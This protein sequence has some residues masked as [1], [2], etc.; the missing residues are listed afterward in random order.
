MMTVMFSTGIR[1]TYNEASWIEWPNRGCWLL[2]T[3]K[4]GKI[5][6]KIQSSAGVLI[7][8]REPCTITAPPVATVK[9]ALQFL[10]NELNRTPVTGWEE[11]ALLR[12]LKAKLARFDSRK[13]VWR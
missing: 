13:K 8:W 4:D 3:A 2:K 1:V 12:E 9:T 11:A 7:E 10:V 6:A 5:I